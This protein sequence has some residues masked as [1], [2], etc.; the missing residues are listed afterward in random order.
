M[1]GCEGRGSSCTTLSTRSSGEAVRGMKKVTTSTALTKEE[2]LDAIAAWVHENR[3]EILAPHTAA[4]FDAD[5]TTER[6]VA[7]NEGHATI[8][9]TSYPREDET[10]P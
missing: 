10:T 6:M 8:T 9:F 3:P 4:A 1:S 7:V 2:F 5:I